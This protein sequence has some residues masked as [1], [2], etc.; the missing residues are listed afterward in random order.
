MA[1]GFD[2]IVIDVVLLA[3]GALGTP[4]RGLEMCL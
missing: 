2:D 1:M 3:L 4:T